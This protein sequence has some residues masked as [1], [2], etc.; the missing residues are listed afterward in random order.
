[1]LKRRI[2]KEVSVARFSYG[3]V[4]KV[5]VSFISVG[6]FV[7][8]FSNWYFFQ[9]VEEIWIGENKDNNVSSKYEAYVI[10]MASKLAMNLN[11]CLSR[12]LC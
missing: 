11:R 8:Y 2:C 6:Y 10:F 12:Q 9:T 7:L 4:S 3:A 5:P 1:M